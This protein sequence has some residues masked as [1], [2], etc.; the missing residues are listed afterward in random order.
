MRNIE[1]GQ[2]VYLDY[3]SQP[4]DGGPHYVRGIDHGIPVVGRLKPEDIEAIGV[5][6]KNL[7]KTLDSEEI[8]RALSEGDDDFI[9]AYEEIVYSYIN[10]DGLTNNQS[11]E[12]SA[13]LNALF[14]NLPEASLNLGVF[15][16]FQQISDPA[17][18]KGLQVKKSCPFR[19]YA[20]A[21]DRVARKV[22]GERGLALDKAT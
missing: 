21:W 1:I 3:H 22:R 18:M 2:K 9:E 5:A 8:I 7:G 12:L 6:C 11:I 17:E 19:G 16:V 4:T 15:E 20:T 13:G 14:D 10:I